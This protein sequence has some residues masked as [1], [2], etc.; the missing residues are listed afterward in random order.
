MNEQQKH[1]GV[2]QTV[3][4][5]EMEV[6]DPKRSDFGKISLEGLLKEKKWVILCFYPADFTFVCPTELSDLALKYEEL[7]KLGAEVIS[8]STDT[9]FTH[10]AW[11]DNEKLMA[12]VKYPMAADPTGTVSRLFGVYDEGSGLALRGTF[13]IN[14]EGK[15]IAS[16]TNFYNVGRNMDELL[17]KMK[18]NAYLVT[19]A[20]EACPAKWE[21]GGKT[22]K[23]NPQMV[24]KVYE[25]L[26]K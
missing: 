24:G 8:V 9:K 4:N 11:K 25:A 26:N 22:L 1:V 16:E 18:A 15:L 19:H 6:Y 10:L 7:K 5:F 13:I 12:N 23:P 20:D 14:P 21:Q 2:G 3:P 17:R